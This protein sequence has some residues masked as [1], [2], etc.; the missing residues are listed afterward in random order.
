VNRLLATVA[1]VALA[2][3]PAMADPTGDVKGALI[4]LA[5][6]SSYHVTMTTAS[7][8]TVTADFVKPAK[9]HVVAGPMELIEI[10]TTTYVKMSSTWHQF[11]FPGIEHMMGPLSNAQQLVKSHD[12]IVVTDLGPKSVDGTVLHAYGVKPGSSAKAVTMYLDASGSLV[13]IDAAGP[14]GTNVVR[15]SNVNVPV[16]IDA[17]V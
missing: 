7:G 14:G 5:G 9:I 11:S 1:L 13:R 6:A 15:F 12:D 4:A 2:F 16:T 3:A 10:G 17:P 8:Q